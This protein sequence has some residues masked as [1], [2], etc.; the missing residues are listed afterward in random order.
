MDVLEAELRQ[1][2]LEH[3]EDCELAD[4]VREID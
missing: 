2:I 3:G 4:L 1:L